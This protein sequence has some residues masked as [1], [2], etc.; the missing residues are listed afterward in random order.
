[1]LALY[2]LAHERVCTVSHNSNCN[3]H[4]LRPCSCH[5]LRSLLLS[6]FPAVV[7]LCILIMVRQTAKSRMSKPRPTK[8][9][10]ASAYCA[11]IDSRLP[12]WNRNRS[13]RTRLTLGRVP[14]A[15]VSLR[16]LWSLDKMMV[17]SCKVAVIRRKWY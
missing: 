5:G 3:C 9:G 10:T 13:S 17:K 14:K 12:D 4:G 15:T 1:M 6:R 11:G 7:Y 8:G 16:N 2:S